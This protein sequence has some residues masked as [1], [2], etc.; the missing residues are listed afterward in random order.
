MAW[1][2]GLVSITF[3]KLTPAEIIALVKQTPLAGIEWGGDIHVPHGDVKRA[4]EVGRMTRD[5]G[6][7]VSAYGSYYGETDRLVF[8]RVLDS[9]V[10]LGAPVIR[11]WA[12]RKGSAAAGRQIAFEFHGGSLA[13]TPESCLRLLQAVNH[14]AVF[15]YWQPPSRRALRIA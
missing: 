11:I 15:T 5:A 2:A 4:A 8:E 6:L 1:L 9:A 13:D 7:A 3:R 10:A 12:G 14:P